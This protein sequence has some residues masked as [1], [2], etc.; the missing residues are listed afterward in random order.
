M[1]PKP[2]SNSKSP[3][4][5]SAHTGDSVLKR[6][7]EMSQGLRV[8]NQGQFLDLSHADPD[9]F[10]EAMNVVVETRRRFNTLP[11]RLRAECLNDPR[12]LLTLVHKARSGDDDAISTLKMCKVLPKNYTHDSKPP[13]QE[14]KPPVQE[15]LV[16]Q[17]EKSAA[18]G[19][20]G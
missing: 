1:Q 19:S 8:S 5:Q 2:K 3:V 7:H 20:N 12:N 15:D 11:A 6:V 17:V 18:G 9:N 10:I 4:V 16:K 13:V 14:P